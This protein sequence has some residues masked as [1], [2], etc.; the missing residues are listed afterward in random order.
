MAAL[1]VGQCH[2]CSFQLTTAVCFLQGIGADAVVIAVPLTQLQKR[3]IT[4]TPALPAPFTKM[5][6]TINVQNAVKVFA[7]FDQAFWEQ[8]VHQS[9]FKNQAAFEGLYSPGAWIR[10]NANTCCILLFIHYLIVT[11]SSLAKR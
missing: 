4:F 3:A 5:V 9:K 1:P 8:S 7:L 2:S 10:Y 11:T 6:D